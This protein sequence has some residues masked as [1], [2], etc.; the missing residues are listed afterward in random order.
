[1]GAAVW[2]ALPLPAAQESARDEPVHRQPWGKRVCGR[3]SIWDAHST[4]LLAPILMLV[5]PAFPVG[6]L[7]ILRDGLGPPN[8][9]AGLTGA[10]TSPASAWPGVDVKMP[11][12]IVFQA[13]DGSVPA[14]EG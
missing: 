13:A 5:S 4:P 6:K 3:L 11:I 7:A 10:D 14:E 9:D 2:R 1:M 8:C 12:G